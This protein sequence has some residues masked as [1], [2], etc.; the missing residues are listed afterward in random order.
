MVAGVVAIVILRHRPG[1]AFAAAI[2]T[3]VLANPAVHDGS[4]AMLL[5]ALLP[6]ARRLAEGQSGTAAAG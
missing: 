6:W 5:P 3:M 4:Y 2:I 1:A